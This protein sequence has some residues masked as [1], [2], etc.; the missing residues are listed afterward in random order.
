M[1]N[2][3]GLG[4][5]VRGPSQ[6]GLYKGYRWLLY[7]VTCDQ[8][9]P[10]APKLKLRWWA[11]SMP[12]D[13]AGAGRHT[14]TCHGHGSTNDKPG[15][16]PSSPWDQYW[17]FKVSTRIPTSHR[18]LLGWARALVQEQLILRIRGFPFGNTP[19]RL[20]AF[21]AFQGLIR[22]PLLRAFRRY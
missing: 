1:G 15:A 22:A 3:S 5:R 16:G 14:W 19:A 13:L 21:A 20:K 17:F 18:L 9:P 10:Q 8:L 7:G 4:W 6:V 2:M 11:A 12:L